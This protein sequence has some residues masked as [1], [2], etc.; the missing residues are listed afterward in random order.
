M[1]QTAAL[2]LYLWCKYGAL[3]IA[4]KMCVY[5]HP[6]LRL[7]L[8]LVLGATPQSSRVMPLVAD[9]IWLR[10]FVFRQSVR[11]H[12]PW[13]PSPPRSF[14][15]A[16]KPTAPP[17]LLFWRL[18]PRP[19]H[20]HHRGGPPCWAR[21][22]SPWSPCRR[23][24]HRPRALLQ[25]MRDATLLFSCSSSSYSSRSSDGWWSQTIFKWCKLEST[26]IHYPFWVSDLGI[27]SWR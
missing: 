13:H 21:R 16:P 27:H 6:C 7:R 20:P 12:G 26:K 24:F 4:T 8:H 25:P 2:F 5:L 10:T 11:R 17:P 15:V 19:H 14:V 9:R 1:F 22:A 18:V 23:G 3:S